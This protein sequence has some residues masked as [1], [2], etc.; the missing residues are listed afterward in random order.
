MV[1]GDSTRYDLVRVD[2]TTGKATTVPRTAPILGRW[3]ADEERRRLEQSNRDPNIVIE[4]RKAGM[5]QGFRAAAF[6]DVT[7]KFKNF[8]DE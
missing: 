2:R 7:H 1:T 4:V 6:S 5:T 3:L 8:R